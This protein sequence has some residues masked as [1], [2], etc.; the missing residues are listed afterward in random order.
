VVTFKDLMV[1]Q[2]E[3]FSDIEEEK[4]FFTAEMVMPLNAKDCHLGVWI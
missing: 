4:E 1:F 2:A 3:S